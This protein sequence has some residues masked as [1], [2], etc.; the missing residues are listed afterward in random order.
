MLVHPGRQSTS[1]FPWSYLISVYPNKST[2]LLQRLPFFRN[3]FLPL[4][5]S[6]D[7][8]RDPWFPPGSGPS[9]HFLS[10]PAF[11][12]HQDHPQT[13]VTTSSR[14]ATAP[15]A[16]TYR[17]NLVSPF[18][19]SSFNL[20]TIDSWMETTTSIATE[21]PSMSGGCRWCYSVLRSKSPRA[22]AC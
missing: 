12:L 15:D 3:R 8:L 20:F 19:S 4:L 11:L 13:K 17:L 16:V 6:P 21:A 10:V 14:K 9:T 5:Y 22:Q 2:P 18:D 1:S 7:S